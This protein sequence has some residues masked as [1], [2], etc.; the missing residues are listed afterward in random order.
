MLYNPSTQAEIV[1]I[2]GV[3][4]DYF[5]PETYLKLSP[6]VP[7]IEVILDDPDNT[8]S[9]TFANFINT[10]V[11]IGPAAFTLASGVKTGIY[12]SSLFTGFSASPY[13]YPI[14]SFS[15]KI[16]ANGTYN[17]TINA[18]CYSHN[19]PSIIYVSDTPLPSYITHVAIVS[20]HLQ[21]IQIDFVK[22]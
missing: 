14:Q 6:L 3:D 18:T 19:D 5:M 9:S 11:G 12:A 15:V 7:P 20:S 21:S 17:V 2:V 22:A 1:S 10:A 13:P 4:I 8:V 16:K